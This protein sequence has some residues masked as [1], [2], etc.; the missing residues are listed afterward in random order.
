MALF[1]ET[2][3]KF[4]YDQKCAEYNDLLAKYHALRQSGYDPASK[5]RMIP[6]RPDSAQQAMIAGEKIFTDPRVGRAFAQCVEEGMSEPDALREAYRL[7]GVATGRVE[8]T[9]AG[10]SLPDLAAGAS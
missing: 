4:V 2:V 9:S 8:P 7:V 3:P 5:L 10:A 1:K 6:P